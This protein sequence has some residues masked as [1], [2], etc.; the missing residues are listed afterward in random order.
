MSVIGSA[1]PYVRPTPEFVT[2]LPPPVAWTEHVRPYAV[3]ALLAVAA[4]LTARLTWH[5]YAR[6]RRDNVPER[7]ARPAD[8]HSLRR[9]KLH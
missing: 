9:K 4:L 7:V 6:W 3:Y 1:R 8:R 5:M 2:P